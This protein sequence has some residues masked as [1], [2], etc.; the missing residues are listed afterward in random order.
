M[1]GRIARGKEV[2]GIRDPA[3][4][5]RMYTLRAQESNEAASSS[6]SSSAEAS[7]V[8]PLGSL[9]L[10]T[11]MWA[12]WVKEDEEAPLGNPFE[13]AFEELKAGGATGPLAHD[14]N[15]YFN[16]QTKPL[17]ERGGPLVTLPHRFTDLYKQLS[18]CKCKVT[19]N[20]PEEPAI[21]LVCGEVLCAGTAC[22]KRDGI[23]ALTRHVRTC[24]AGVGLFLLVNRTHTVLLRGPHAPTRSLRTSM[25]TARRTRVYAAAGRYT[26]CRADAHA[27]AAVGL[28]WRR[29]RGRKGA[30]DARSRRE[31]GLLLMCARRADMYEW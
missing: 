12:G 19:H 14:F 28:A 25:N 29:G 1:G 22:C 2:P 21:C 18:A 15:Q 27:R 13:S 20:A 17:R 10:A 26:R 16:M 24:G 31:R 6:S 9:L 23:G 5:D 7:I 8:E 3:E 30:S 4:F 11:K